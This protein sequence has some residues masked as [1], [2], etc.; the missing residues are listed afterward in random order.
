MLR[1]LKRE[2][3]YTFTENAAKAH[4]TTENYLLDFFAQGGAL[5]NRDEDEIVEL[6]ARAFATNEVKALKLLFYFRDVRGGQGERRMFRVI[7]SHLIKTDPDVAF[8]IMKLIP[9]YG[10]WDDLYV[11]ADTS[12]E[13]HMFSLMAEQLFQDVKA[14]QN[15]QPISLLAKWMKSE[16]T[17][18][19]VNYLGL[20]TR[21]ALTLTSKEYRKLLSAL[22]KYID[23]VERKMSAKEWDEINFEKVPSQAMF[24]YS[25]AF[26]RQSD[27][28][29]LYLN[30]V[31]SGE[32]TIAAKTLYPHQI[33][34]QVLDGYSY[35]KAHDLQWNALP[36]FLG[37]ESADALVMADVS[38]SMFHGYNTIPLH[39]SVGLAIYIAERMEGAYHN[40]FLTFSREPDLV[41][42]VG[43]NIYE[44]VNMVRKSDWGMN[45]DLEAAMLSILKT[46]INNNISPKELPKRLIVISDMEFDRGSTS[47][48]LSK[49][50]ESTYLRYGYKLPKIVWW[51]VDARN[52]QFPMTKTDNCLMVSGASPEIISAV[53][54]DDFITPVGLME[55]VINR[56]R[57]NLID[58][59][60]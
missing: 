25:R 33:V 7:L 47:S 29:E 55:N 15:D 58:Q 37:G 43:R 49:G 28:Y 19:K 52:T 24:K 22:R 4:R 5:R 12:L 36:N 30:Q 3:N 40:H 41:E 1:E 9:E 34:G 44:K 45:T 13:K 21:N 10:R 42:I 23:I 20:K 39:V 6:F 14:Y 8:K 11:Y 50:I 48:Y 38:G 26:A 27:G 46:A 2:L 54:K 16:R 56:E 53:L 35:D 32:K 18:G 60:L 17:H 31:E 59:V 51:N 57:Y